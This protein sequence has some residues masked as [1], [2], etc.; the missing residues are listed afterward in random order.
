MLTLC[1]LAALP[2]TAAP[3][4]VAGT[5]RVIDGDTL[6]VGQTRIRLFGID[7]V[8]ASQS[9]RHPVEGDWSCGRD[10]KREVGEWLNGRTLRCTRE[11]TD[12][13]GRMVATCWLGEVDVGG[14]LVDAG[15]AFAYPKYSARYETRQARAL[16][17]GRGLWTSVV[18]RPDLY[19]DRSGALAD[20][21]AV[22]GQ[23]RI[24]GNISSKGEKIYHVPGQAYYDKTRISPQKGERWFCSEAEARQ[25]GWRKARL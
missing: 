18:L 9:C 19:R 10:V 5:A 17:A 25:A 20:V 12:R 21:Q 24:K 13:Y 7:A 3:R 15:L 11:D 2:V 1:L 22:Q 8:E 16:K 14:A 6:D 4:E 23:C